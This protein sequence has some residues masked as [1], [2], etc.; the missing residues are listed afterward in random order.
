MTDQ[1]ERIKQIIAHPEAAGRENLA[2]RLAFDTDLPAEKCI[3]IMSVAPR[4][5]AISRAVE[6]H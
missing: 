2:Q 4:A 6:S 3:D 1:K 5:S